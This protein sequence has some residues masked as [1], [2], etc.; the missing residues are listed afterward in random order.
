LAHQE[1]LQHIQHL[2]LG[3]QLFA[4]MVV[5]TGLMR[6]PV[7]VVHVLVLTTVVE[8]V[9]MVVTLAVVM[10]LAAVLVG[11]QVLVVMAEFLLGVVAV[12]QAVE[13]VAVL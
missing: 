4:L 2:P 7:L 13:V 12:H 6:R 11:T 3:L 9:E 10:A 1:G 5:E 8:M